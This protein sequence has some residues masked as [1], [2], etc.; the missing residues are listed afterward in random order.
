M[1]SSLY[2][3]LYRKILYIAGLFTVLNRT[4]VRFFFF[5]NHTVRFGAVFYFFVNRTVR[6]GAVFSFSKSYG[7]VRCGIYFSRIVRCGAVW[8][9]VEQLF[10][11]VRLSVHRS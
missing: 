1:Y 11:T 5:R 4:A 8:L 6:C 10:P 7:A 2:K 9:S 3:Y